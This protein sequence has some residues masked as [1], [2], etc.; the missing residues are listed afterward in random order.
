MVGGGGYEKLWG[1]FLIIGASLP[2]AYI[3]GAFM[4][5]AFMSGAFLQVSLFVVTPTGQHVPVC[6]GSE[7]L[8]SV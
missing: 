6:P 2:G 4:P 7:F 8:F 3:H 1:A 5:G